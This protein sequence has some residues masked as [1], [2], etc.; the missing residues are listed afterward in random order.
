MA[1]ARIGIGI[2]FEVN[3]QQLQNLQT[4]LRKIQ[5]MS[6][7]KV[8]KINP[9]MTIGELNKIKETAK[10]VEHAMQAAFNPKL[11]MVNFSAFKSQLQA[12]GQ[13]VNALAA[14]FAKIGPTGAT[15]AN[16]MVSS[17][18]RVNKVFRQTTSIGEQLTTTLWNTMKWSI[19]S[20]ALQTI[21]S[22]IQKA[23]SYSV[24]LDESLNNIR[25]VTGQ[26]AEQMEK[27][28]KSANTAAKALGT[29]TTTY[30]DAALI[31]YQQGLNDK[32]VMKRAET[33][34]K[35]ANVTGQ[36]AQE[37]SEQLTAV[38]N[39]YRVAA[40]EAEL[41]IDKLAAVAAS[42]ASDLE[43]LSD[44]M[45][46][47][48][49]G[50][51]AM[52]VNIDQLTAQLSTIISVTRQDASSVGNALKTIY[53]RM[54]DLAVAG[55]D[56]FGV[57]LGDVSGKLKQ[58]G[59]DVL[60]SEGNLRDM[61]DVI[62]EVAEKWGG[63]TQAQQQAA[64]VALAG[65]RQYNNLIALFE[66]W[67]MYEESLTT[68]Q[69]SEGTLEQQQA[70]YMESIQAKLEQLKAAGE[71]VYQA[72]FENAG[73]GEI[74]ETV[75]E[76][77]DG[78]AT[79]VEN[80]GGL[81][82]ILPGVLGL[83]T[84]MFSGQIAQGVMSFAKNMGIA[85]V[86][87]NKM[88]VARQNI[89]DNEN[90]LAKDRANKTT[91]LAVAIDSRAQ[92]F[93]TRADS[94][95]I[96]R[97]NEL[98]AA[99]KDETKIQAI[100]D[101]YDP[102]IG[103]AQKSFDTR[104]SKLSENAGYSIMSENYDAINNQREK[105]IQ[106]S[107]DEL[108]IQNS[109]TKEQAE[110]L[111]QIR[112]AYDSSVEALNQKRQ[113]LQE[114]K[115][116]TAEL[117]KQLDIIQNQTN[118]GVFGTEA[119]KVEGKKDDALNDADLTQF[120][121]FDLG[122]EKNQAFVNAIGGDA[123]G[124]KE[125]TQEIKAYNAALKECQIAQKDGTLTVG[126]Y[127]KL[128][129]A[130]GKVSK[131][132]ADAANKN[133]K[134]QAQLKNNIEKTVN[135]MQDLERAE[136]EATAAHQDF[137]KKTKTEKLVKDVTNLA[138]SFMSLGFTIQAIQGLGSIWK[139][140]DLSM[141]EKWIQT[142]TQL[143]FVLPGLIGPLKAFM[144]F[145]FME[146]ASLALKNKLLDSFYSKKTRETMQRI[147]NAA[148]TDKETEKVLQEN[149]AY[150]V[151]GKLVDKNG[152]QLSLLSTKKLFSTL[153]AN[154]HTAALVVE[155]K[156]GERT[157]NKL[158]EAGIKAQLGWW[159]IL[160]IGLA[161]AAVL[162][163]IIGLIA[164]FM[165]NT[166]SALEKAQKS[167]EQANKDLEQ[168]KSNLE[169]VKQAQ[170]ELNSSFDA[171]DKAREKINSLVVGTQEWRDAVLENNQAVLE[172]ISNNAAL[173]EYVTT[174][175]DGVMTISAEGRD[176]AKSAAAANVAQAQANVYLQ[177]ADVLMK[178]NNVLLEQQREEFFEQNWV[179]NE[180]TWKN[181]NI[182][183]DEYQ[184]IINFLAEP[185]NQSAEAVKNAVD[186]P[187]AFAQYLND[188][189]DINV[190]NDILEKMGEEIDSLIANTSAIAVNSQATDML[191]EAYVRSYVQENEDYQEA[192]NKEAFVDTF[193]AQLE[194]TIDTS[195]YTGAGDKNNDSATDKLLRDFAKSQGV[196]KS[197]LKIEDGKIKWSDGETDHEISIETA[198]KQAAQYTASGNI[199]T[200]KL[201]KIQ[202]A[203][204]AVNEAFGSVSNK[205]TAFT[206]AVNDYTMSAIEYIRTT[207]AEAG[208]SINEY[209]AT[210]GWDTL[211]E[212]VN[213]I[214]GLKQNLKDTV[215][216][217][218]N[219]MSLAVKDAWDNIAFDKFNFDLDTLNNIKSALTNAFKTGGA[220]GLNNIKTM[221]G[222]FAN[223]PEMMKAISGAIANVDLSSYDAISQVYNNLE[224]AGIEITD[225]I[226]EWINGLDSFAN[227]TATAVQNFDSIVD[228]LHTIND[229]TKDLK[230]G[231]IIDDEDYKTLI[232]YDVRMRDFFV[233]TADGYKLVKGSGKE[234]NTMLTNNTM[235]LSQL[236]EEY[237]VLQGQAEGL[238]A[239]KENN[240]SAFATTGSGQDLYS[241]VA[242]ISGSAYREVLASQG[243]SSDFVQDTLNTWLNA[244]SE[245]AREKARE[246]LATI[247]QAADA[248]TSADLS[249]LAAEE[250]WIA[251]Y[252][253]SLDDVK[254]AY[255]EGEISAEAYEK[256]RLMYLNSY[257]EFAGVS[258][259][260][261]REHWDAKIEEAEKANNEADVLNIKLEEEMLVQNLVNAAL[262]EQQE[263]LEVINTE[264][265]SLVNKL[266]DIED[267]YDKLS[268]IGGSAIIGNL[269]HQ[270]ELQN[271]ILAK[272]EEAEA[273]AASRY[274]ANR[275]GME[276][277]AT[278]YGYT[279]N[280]IS[281]WYNADGTIKSS[282]LTSLYTKAE[283][284][285]GEERQE[286]LDWIN[287]SVLGVNEYAEAWTNAKDTLEDTKDVIQDL[288]FSKWE[289]E[290]TIKIDEKET[291]KEF[292]DWQKEFLRDYEF[293]AKMNFESSNLDATLTQG[294]AY[295]DQL[296]ELYEVRK[297][298]EA[299]GYDERF[300]SG[301]EGLANVQAAINAAMEG[302]KESASEAYEY[303]EEIKNI[304]IESLD[305][306]GE[307]FDKVEESA[308]NIKEVFESQMS[309][310][311]LIYGDK[312]YKRMKDYY[313][314]VNTQNKALQ[315]NAKEE[316]DWWSARVD[317]QNAKLAAAASEQERLAIL[318]S[319][320]Y[321]TI[322]SNYQE[323]VG[324]WM[325]SIETT[326]QGLKDEF[327]NSINAVF[328]EL[329]KGLSNMSLD[330]AIE[331]WDLIGQ[332][333]DKYLDSVNRSY[334]ISKL[335]AEYDK[336]IKNSSSIKQQEEL[337]KL[338][339]EE[340]K[341]LRSRENLT[342]DDI[343]RANMRLELA[344]KQL[345][346]EEA[347]NTATKMRMTRD[348]YGNYTYSFVED[349]SE[350]ETL[351]QELADLQ[352]QL[353]NFDKDAVEAIYD[354]ALRLY[355]DYQ[356]KYLEAAAAGDEQMMKML[357]EMYLGK[358]G[359]LEKA[360][361][362][363][364]IMRT[365]FNDTMG[366]LNLDEETK[367]AILD[368][369]DNSGVVKF[370]D[371]L[372]KTPGAL[373]TAS[374]KIK[375]TMS[376]YGTEVLAIV[377]SLNKNLPD[378]STTLKTFYDDSGVFKN[379]IAKEVTE[380]NTLYNKL[381]GTGGLTE[382]L[383]GWVDNLQT[384][385]NSIPT[386]ISIEESENADV[387]Y[388]NTLVDKIQKGPDEYLKTSADILSKSIKDW[389]KLNKEDQERMIK[390]HA[391]STYSKD[392][393][394]AQ[395]FYS[396]MSKTD[397]IRAE[398][399]NESLSTAAN[400]VKQTTDAQSLVNNVNKEYGNLDWNNISS[401]KS[402][403]I[404]K[405]IN[406]AFGKYGDLDS[407]EKAFIYGNNFSTYLQDSSF[408]ASSAGDITDKIKNWNLSK[409][410]Y[411]D[412][413][414]Y[415]QYNNLSQED[416]VK[417]KEYLGETDLQYFIDYHQAFE[418]LSK[419]MGGI[420]SKFIEDVFE[421]DAESNRY[422][423]K[424][425]LRDFEDYLKAT[426][427]L[428]NYDKANR[429]T[430]D[431]FNTTYPGLADGLS[432]LAF[433]YA[434]KYLDNPQTYTKLRWFT[435]EDLLSN[436]YWE[437]VVEKSKYSSL[438]E[439]YENLN[440]SF[441]DEQYELKYGHPPYLI[442]SQSGANYFNSEENIANLKDG[443]TSYEEAAEQMLYFE[444]A[445][446]IPVFSQS[447][448]GSS[449]Y[450]SKPGRTVTIDVGGSQYQLISKDLNE[451]FIKE[452]IYRFNGSQ[453]IPT[454][455]S[456][457]DRDTYFDLLYMQYLSALR[458]SIVQQFDTGG[459]TGDWSSSDGRL[460]VLHEKELVLNK[461]DTP[462]IL[463]A[464]Q[465][466]RS[467]GDI[468]NSYSG[469]LAAG[470]KAI[471]DWNHSSNNMNVSSGDI[472]EQNVQIEATFPNATDKRE[473]Q[474]AMNN[475]INLAAQKIH[476]D[477]K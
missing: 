165:K 261:W 329:E 116:R 177:Q 110:Q 427:I 283:G 75:T 93:K 200:K 137:I 144:S 423:I 242:A 17:M 399:S 16:Q 465:I 262:V 3:K 235:G 85:S 67:D 430:K 436:V 362:R 420:D 7:E 99:G 379:A 411:T 394:T 240:A 129:E 413:N 135:E 410:K 358:N 291:E 460:A 117:Q 231:E 182:S 253:D 160:V 222:K 378:V 249:S 14:T 338:K 102:K 193:N 55:K 254:R 127:N 217:M 385:I 325:G 305:A 187:K 74:I 185:I 47:V 248:A 311:Q 328:E 133:G 373:S 375:T 281:S 383:N 387:K 342:E 271:Q 363:V 388:F 215:N 21:S 405:Q 356:S 312:Q 169:A 175:K 258:T 183:T 221:L 132:A 143:S 462:N 263:T 246:G 421:K 265:D 209:L 130:Q 386:T 310:I 274:E 296:T 247:L 199:D 464:V 41:Y 364:G 319:E 173:A 42:T 256:G 82:T 24:Q 25:I 314:S 276:A 245:D 68:S 12:A 216:N 324:N 350:I 346:L 141:G 290:F 396:G 201:I 415:R 196:E 218:S 412:N 111:T 381:L 208:V 473:I 433:N 440:Q 441:L 213:D 239:L 270:L 170:D 390:E 84:Q 307:A 181:S 450:S 109:L 368:V 128:V 194:K 22:S 190:D 300:G 351:R 419:N 207:A 15:M 352:N 87:A 70:I 219:N 159:P 125:A 294:K 301:E 371:E 237:E 223:D 147:I 472:L 104:V 13:D 297:I 259:E 78:I 230:V 360:L 30:T 120:Q 406:N 164:L 211:D 403:F 31:Y 146:N 39:G 434:Y 348:V 92:G 344:T 474:E 140:E 171:Y 353:Y 306:M 88:N 431:S 255:Y 33:T 26:S 157:G 456:Y 313:N 308:N 445:N 280:D 98:K 123:Q 320:E 40:D 5:N 398:K 112:S 72:L 397:Q 337:N 409:E 150:V 357:D 428:N 105:S 145:S 35:A 49:S 225:E 252:T 79:L 382:K 172:L 142:L 444:N 180:R 131:R 273:V 19:A 44:G 189:L 158:L 244:E 53:A 343:K 224:L 83:M 278:I 466:V 467:I 226:A 202:N 374:D 341:I 162:A 114:E 64:A 238:T 267:I 298:I 414:T 119:T 155:G 233:K 115:L 264:V 51:N 96:Q 188:N 152:K 154:G 97:D 108:A 18:T 1:N 470:A 121:E 54:G 268:D 148:A 448:I 453:F 469:E 214:E 355:K 275:R 461:Q 404:N 285:E 289:A 437:D 435:M 191:R 228:R 241:R 429:I 303:L 251:Q 149:G 176:E 59:I 57:A 60:N 167:Y 317:E 315:A 377:D 400:K 29:Q 318:Q 4:E 62:T 134:S 138:G 43:E 69:T 151:N 139:D 446:Q 203:G 61:G 334:N 38:W 179:G 34:V 402:S 166:E 425:D 284:Y 45:S 345:A 260:R 332:Y 27:F 384:A 8:T 118:Q 366:L 393:S 340:L 327:V 243:V 73:T 422:K 210:Q 52:G 457:K 9:S 468:L 359:L 90:Q 95:T 322:T 101:K 302:A 66:N 432:S 424:R 471:G 339:N 20:T 316:L 288:L 122:N 458:G 136:R 77:V 197:D 212:A 168:M 452:F 459:Y 65:K 161:I 365:N 46:K 23:W 463:A 232:A 56:E 416:K 439:I 304:Y 124:T 426:N 443:W 58:M 186:N 32:E 330:V 438:Q 309:I 103:Q 395:S 198:T 50:A 389:D 6:L 369:W 71:G 81:K 370:V 113:T 236:K 178:K 408:S 229:I 11:G 269:Q 372:A 335:A 2:D 156:E 475:L 234:I 442:T 94:L 321:Q 367:K 286:Y 279:A 361:D 417:I 380:L 126:Q 163:I 86:N 447:S 336:A 107:K 277:S 292:N 192:I 10:T 76:L 347:Q 295:T 454:D 418:D 250:V 37:V 299:G 449:D 106:M 349:Q 331:E 293:T 184:K 153:A 455:V 206:G 100:K 204:L 333:N 477:K 272:Q 91:N 36:S 205:T 174:D 401:E 287:N 48:A 266:E 326:I 227:L 407:K 476:E 63:W 89:A 28:A 282:I 391:F 323:A 220:D 80:L 392:V 354:E 195:V 376:S 257:I 451:D